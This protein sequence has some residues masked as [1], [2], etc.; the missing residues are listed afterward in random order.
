MRKYLD[1]EPRLMAL[2]Q[3]ELSAER[4][5]RSWIP[6]SAARAALDPIRWSQRSQRERSWQTFG[7]LAARPS[8]H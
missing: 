4:E 6:H 5:A 2:S 7:A 3:A 8:L 1:L